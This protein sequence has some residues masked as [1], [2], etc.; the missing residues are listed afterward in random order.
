MGVSEIQKRVELIL[1]KLGVEVD[2]GA[3]LVEREGE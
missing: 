2:E 1:D 3:R